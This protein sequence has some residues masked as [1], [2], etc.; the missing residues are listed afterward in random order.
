M[1]EREK[2]GFIPKVKRVVNGIVR[3]TWPFAAL[4]DGIVGEVWIGG[5]L[6]QMLPPPPKP[7]YRETTTGSCV[8]GTD[9]ERGKSQSRSTIYKRVFQNEFGTNL[10]DFAAEEVEITGND[11]LRVVGRSPQTGVIYQPETVETYDG[12][13]VT[14]WKASKQRELAVQ[15]GQT[16]RVQACSFEM[17]QQ[18]IRTK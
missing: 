1:S 7:E 17:R 8:S 4:I 5:Q 3:T 6:N 10:V 18:K 9:V 2:I 16:Q 12:T 11:A 14:I 15:L 13:P